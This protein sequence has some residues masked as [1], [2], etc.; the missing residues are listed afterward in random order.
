MDINI[1]K[2][3]KV[4]VKDGF[5]QPAV[6]VD[7]CATL[8]G[9]IVSKVISSKASGGYKEDRDYK[10]INKTIREYNLSDSR[11]DVLS[12]SLSDISIL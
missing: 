3:N 4:E 11:K 12:K 1:L 6:F 10:S 8:G 7:V 9:A 2:Q 5:F